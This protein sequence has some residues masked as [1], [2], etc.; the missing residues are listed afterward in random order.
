MQHFKC[1]F[2]K[3]ETCFTPDT[4]Y[5]FDITFHFVPENNLNFQRK[6]ESMF[7]CRNIATGLKQ[8]HGPPS[9]VCYCTSPIP[10]PITVQ[11]E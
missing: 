1:L 2:T 8:G 5:F 6:M 10:C 11:C 9:I 3:R 7:S 4:Y